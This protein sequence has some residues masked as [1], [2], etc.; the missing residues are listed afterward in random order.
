M[1]CSFYDG[2]ELGVCATQQE[3]IDP[4]RQ[5]VLGNQVIDAR[6]RKFPKRVMDI[7]ELNEQAKVIDD[8]K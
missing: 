7:R 6:G 2:A 8:L 4:R 3:T 1:S 5:M